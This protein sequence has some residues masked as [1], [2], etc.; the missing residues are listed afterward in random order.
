MAQT[1]SRHSTKRANA[2]ANQARLRPARRPL[3]YA[4]AGA[5]AE[6]GTRLVMRINPELR[7]LIERAAELQGRKMSEFV[8]DALRRA[9]KRA[10]AEAA[11][12]RLSLADQEL[13][14]ETLLA[15]PNPTRALRRAFAR[16][17]QLVG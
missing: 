4:N 16:R 12:L 7:A 10:I 17:R 15:P 11:M 13:F 9:A 3:A 5:A 14:A 2:K 6:K 8:T 1:G